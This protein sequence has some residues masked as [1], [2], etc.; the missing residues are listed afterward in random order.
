MT[1]GICLKTLTTKQK[2][3]FFFLFIYFPQR[4][5][6]LFSRISLATHSFKE[7]GKCILTKHIA[8]SYQI[9]KEGTM[10]FV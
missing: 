8:S 7:A 5:D 9:R 3:L 4:G 10:M 2:V 6:T 1:I